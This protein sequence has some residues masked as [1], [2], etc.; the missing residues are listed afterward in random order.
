[1]NTNKNYDLPFCG[2]LFLVV[3]AR[4]LKHFVENK[5][6]LYG[7]WGPKASQDCPGKPQRHLKSSKT[8]QKRGSK[9][10]LLFET[11]L[12]EAKMTKQQDTPATVQRG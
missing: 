8:S 9:T 5:L 6:G 10:Q 12:A 2:N 1:M 7:L 11:I 3:F 4:N